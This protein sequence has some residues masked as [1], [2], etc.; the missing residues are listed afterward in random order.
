MYLV[1]FMSGDNQRGV[2]ALEVVPRTERYLD[3]A[4][5]PDNLVTFRFISSNTC[6]LLYIRIFV[7]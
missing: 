7:R 2:M 6:T 1:L 5:I 3:F 4:Q